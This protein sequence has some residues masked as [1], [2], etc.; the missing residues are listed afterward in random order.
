MQ[1]YIHACSDVPTCGLSISSLL[2]YE[3]LTIF[4]F[5]VMWNFS[6]IWW[7]CHQTLHQGGTLRHD[8]NLKG[9]LHVTM[10]MQITLHN[11]N[12][13]QFAILRQLFFAIHDGNLT[14]FPHL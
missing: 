4:T 10:A 2:Q 3:V 13:K 11:H 14:N 5:I 9:V 1:V 8:G 6:T 12:A 7:Y